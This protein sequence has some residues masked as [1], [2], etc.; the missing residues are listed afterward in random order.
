MQLCLLQCVGLQIYTR[1]FVWLSTALQP[2]NGPHT[3]WSKSVVNNFSVQTHGNTLSGNFL[4]FVTK[5]AFIKAYI[6]RK[7]E[8]NP[9]GG[10]R[11]LSDCAKSLINLF[12]FIQI[13]HSFFLPLSPPTP[14]PVQLRLRKTYVLFSVLAERSWYSS[15]FP[16]ISGL[17][18]Q[19]HVKKE[20]IAQICQIQKAFGENGRGCSVVPTLHHPPLT[21]Y[22]RKKKRLDFKL[23]VWE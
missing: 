18:L 2:L 20:K 13:L 19:C 22:S 15:L 7:I 17:G 1:L 9:F 4:K 23:R 8:N 10:G 21:P 3:S 6:L 12:I 5:I 11:E 14:P 16:V